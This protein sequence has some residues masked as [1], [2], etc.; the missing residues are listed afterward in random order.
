MTLRKAAGWS[1]ALLLALAA[2]GA[3]QQPSCPNPQSPRAL[4]RATVPPLY[5]QTSR[6]SIVEWLPPAQTV[7][8]RARPGCAPQTLRFCGQHYHWPVENI[9]GC[10]GEPKEPG[11]AGAEVKPED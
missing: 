4:N 5:D 11:K 1:A 7:Q 3:A 9:Q 6:Q 8:Y 10:P 2:P